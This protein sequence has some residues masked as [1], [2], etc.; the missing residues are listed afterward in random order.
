MHVIRLL[1]HPIIAPDLHPSIGENIQGPS[2]IRVPEW[3]T[4]RRGAYYL[5]FADHKGG[6]IRLAY[7]DAL[8]GPWTVHGP[9]ALQLEP[10][11]R[12]LDG[13]AEEV[14]ELG[15]RAELLL[16]GR[17][18]DPPQE[19]DAVVRQVLRD[20]LVRREHELL[21]HLVAEVVAA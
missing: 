18:V 5:Y 20:G 4:E 15:E 2:M 11:L 14:R 7:A 6:Y 9:G 21:D 19:G 16:V 13:V 10:V 17:G 1:D 12:P 3:I 8:E